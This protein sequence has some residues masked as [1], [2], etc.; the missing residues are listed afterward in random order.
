MLCLLCSHSDTHSPSGSLSCCFSW[1][2]YCYFLQRKHKYQVLKT[3]VRLAHSRPKPVVGTTTSPC[4]QTSNW[5]RMLLHT[6][7]KKK[8]KKRRVPEIKGSASSRRAPL[9]LSFH[10]AVTWWLC[11]LHLCDGPNPIQSNPVVACAWVQAHCIG[12]SP[13]PWSWSPFSFHSRCLC[14]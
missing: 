1:W 11:L 8:E 3:S 9:S 13:G 7:K 10:W 2:A 14:L 5:K 6:H 4:C 12:L